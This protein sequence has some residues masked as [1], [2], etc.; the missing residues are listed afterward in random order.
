[1]TYVDHFLFLHGC[2][3]PSEKQSRRMD[4]LNSL[5][6]IVK[7][8]R[9]FDCVIDIIGEWVYC[10]NA[11]H[12]GSKLYGLGFWFSKKHDAWV[13]SGSEKSGQATDEPLGEIIRRY[14]WVRIS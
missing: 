12:L 10:F 9:Y 6:G 2:Y 7:R 3:L 1:M 13:F 14:G 8:I 4:Y 11:R 5:W